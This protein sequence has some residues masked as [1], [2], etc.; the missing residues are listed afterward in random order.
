[1]QMSKTLPAPL[2]RWAGRLADQAW[3]VVMVEAVHYM[4]VDWR[5]SVVKPFNEQLANNYPFNPH[6]AQDASLDAFERFFKPD[7]I[8][9]TFYQQNLKLF[10]DN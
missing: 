2:N 3:H 8:L 9:D 5:D 1:R 6:S 4:E 7:G 10:I